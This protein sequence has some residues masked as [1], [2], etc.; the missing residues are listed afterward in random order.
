MGYRRGTGATQEAPGQAQGAGRAET[1]DL[2]TGIDP[3]ELVAAC[4]RMVKAQLKAPDTAEFPGLLSGFKPPV[5]NPETR[6]TTWASWVTAKNPFGVP[7]R[8]YFVCRH[9]PQDGVTLDLRE[10]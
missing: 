1:P 7:M 10:P 4:E 8:L 3:G 2:R 6:R 5:H 9:D